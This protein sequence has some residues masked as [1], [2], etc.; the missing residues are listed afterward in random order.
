M[1][2]SLAHNGMETTVG[3]ATRSLSPLRRRHK[4]KCSADYSVNRLTIKE[5]AWRI[6][7]SRDGALIL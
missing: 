2:L 7:H 5:R 1:G 4:R 6:K 3:G